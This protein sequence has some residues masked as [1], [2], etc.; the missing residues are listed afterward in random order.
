MLAAMACNSEHDLIDDPDV[1]DTDVEVPDPPV[2]PGLEITEPARAA[3]SAGAFTVAGQGTPGDAALTELTIDDQD[4]PLDGSGAFST[5]LDPPAGIALIGARLKDAEGER[6]VDGR[7]VHVGPV[8]PPG[9]TIERA[10]GIQLTDVFLDDDNPDIDDIAGLLE[11]VM[12]HP[13]FGDLVAGQQTT[14]GSIT[15]TIDDMVVDDAEVDIWPGTGVMEVDLTMYDVVSDFTVDGSIVDTTGTMTMDELHIEMDVVV[16]EGSTGVVVQVPY[17][18]AEID[19]FD[20]STNSA[21]VP[22]SLIEPIAE[23]LVESSLEDQAQTLVADLL[24]ELLNAFAFDIPLGEGSP[25]T[26]SLAMASIDAHP[27]GLVMWMDGSVTAT[28]P[29][30]T[31]PDGAGSLTTPGPAPSLP[32]TTNRGLVA[33]VDDDFLNQAM[34]A[35]W[36]AGLVTDLT[37]TGDELTAL[38]GEDLAPP[39]GPVQSATMGLQLPPVMTPPADPAEHGMDMSMGEFWFE[40]TRTDG[41]QVRSSLNVRVGGGI[42]STDESIAIEL[43]NRPRYVTVHAGMMDWPPNLDPGDLASLFR[44]AAPTLM[45]QAGAI[46]PAFPSPSFDLGEFVDTPAVDGIVLKVSGLEHELNEDGWAVIRA[47]LGE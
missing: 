7:S 33:A 3:W 6:A 46:F 41:I 9:A 21:L 28:V 18:S 23:P 15:V 2:L 11:A 30:L 44:L 27:A 37:Y 36:H 31:L 1:P 29:G 26:L 12:T 20:L 35:V 16:V 14:S 43:D 34:F 38:T 5:T 22:D 13:D 10:V 17:V 42:A 4:V 24:G 40:I 45:G 25:V 47:D 8:N 19:G 39:L 32:I